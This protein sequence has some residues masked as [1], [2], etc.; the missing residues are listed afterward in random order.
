MQTHYFPIKSIK[1][2]SIIFM[3]YSCSQ[4]KNVTCFLKLHSMYIRQNKLCLIEIKYF[5]WLYP[6]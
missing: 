3:K 5:N 1:S 2:K 4:T 6:N